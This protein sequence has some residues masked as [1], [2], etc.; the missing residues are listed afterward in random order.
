M[1]PFFILYW[2]S[3]RDC[4]CVYSQ[5]IFFLTKTCCHLMRLNERKIRMKSFPSILLFG[6]VLP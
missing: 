3:D 5:T 2:G 1:Y 4:V 6:K